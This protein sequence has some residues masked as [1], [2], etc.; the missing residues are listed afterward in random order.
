MEIQWIEIMSSY[1]KGLALLVV[2]NIIRHSASSMLASVWLESPYVRHTSL[3]RW[4]S[5][6]LI[7]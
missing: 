5:R 4:F 6:D 3:H 1:P 2:T 7:D